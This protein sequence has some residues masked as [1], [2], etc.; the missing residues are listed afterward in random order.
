MQG[1]RLAKIIIIVI[2]IREEQI[3]EAAYKRYCNDSSVTFGLQCNC[4]E[5][6]AKWAA[7]EFANKV[8]RVSIGYKYDSNLVTKINVTKD[9]IYDELLICLIQELKHNGLIE[10]K[11]TQEDDISTISMCVNVLKNDFRKTM[12]E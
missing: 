12:E 4:F 8:K 10:I 5:E 2:M 3:K 9:I 11:E 7:K 1:N 6:G